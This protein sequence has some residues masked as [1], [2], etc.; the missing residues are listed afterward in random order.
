[1]GIYDEFADAAER[2]EM[3]DWMVE[4]AI[5]RRIERCREAEDRP[6]A[7]MGHIKLDPRLAEWT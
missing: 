3:P 5:A 7:D 2:Y 1:M 6:V 4:K